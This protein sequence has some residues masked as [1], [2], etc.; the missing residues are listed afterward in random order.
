MKEN[1]KKGNL[2]DSPK[3]EKDVGYL[4]FLDLYHIHVIK[5]LFGFLPLISLK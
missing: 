3:K 2:F 1:S 4:V 5:H